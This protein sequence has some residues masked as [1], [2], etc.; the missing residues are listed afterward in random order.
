[1][2]LSEEKDAL[3]KIKNKRTLEAAKTIQAQ[4][5]VEIQS[6]KSGISVAKDMKM[7][8]LMDMVI[9]NKSNLSDNY[10]CTLKKIASYW[11]QFAPTSKV[12]DVT[13]RMLLDFCYWLGTIE[14]GHFV[15]GVRTQCRPLQGCC[16]TPTEKEIVDKVISMRETHTQRGIAKELGI[17]RSTVATIIHRVTKKTPIRR[18]TPGTCRLYLDRMGTFFARAVKMGILP[19]NPVKMIESSEKPRV[20]ESTREYLTIDE[21]RLMSETPCAD[22]TTK[23]MFMFGCFTGLRYSDICRVTWGMIRNK[24]VAITMEKTDKVVHVPLSDNALAWVPK[25]EGHGANDIVFAIH[26]PLTTID[27]RIHKWSAR[28]GIEK[29][30]SFH[31][32][33]HTFATMALTYGADLYTVS[34]L[35]GHSNIAT[36][37]IYAKIVDQKKVDAVNLIPTL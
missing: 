19:A 37:Q 36:T 5:I 13:P 9:E 10:V 30:V 6:N 24:K 33:R 32:S 27:K 17:S 14:E 21:L 29:N 16:R 8:E 7:S 11:N 3:T 2:Y 15:R 23:A 28:A 25:D 26:H 4:R 12:S 20:K 22:E 31:V 35:L 34:K 18:L 1:M